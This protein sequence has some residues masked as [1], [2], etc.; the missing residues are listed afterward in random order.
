MM[1]LD[2]NDSEPEVKDGLINW[3]GTAEQLYD[4][5]TTAGSRASQ[6]RFVKACP[7]PRVLLSQLRNLEKNKPH[8]IGYSRRLEDYPDRIRGAEYWVLFAPDETPVEVE[9][10]ELED[11][12]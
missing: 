4:L 5:L 1:G 12:F 2:N 7:S 8:R 11:L 10:P 6:Q 3:T 9:D